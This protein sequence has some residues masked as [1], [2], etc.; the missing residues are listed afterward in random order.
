MAASVNVVVLAGTIA[1]DPVE[2]RMPSGEAWAAQRAALRT[3][4]WPGLL[5]RVDL[6]STRTVAAL[7][8]SC[9]RSHSSL[10]FATRSPPGS[11]RFYGS[12]RPVRRKDRRF[13]APQR[14]HAWRRRTRF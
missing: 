7:G 12:T 3:I 11:A 1:A 14:H 2:R 4:G 10:S 9:S 13:P 6:I 5:A 8:R